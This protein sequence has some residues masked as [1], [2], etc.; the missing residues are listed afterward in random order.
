MKLPLD[1]G[2]SVVV[3]ERGVTLVVGQRAVALPDINWWRT[4]DLVVN[5]KYLANEFRGRS[6]SR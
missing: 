2:N 3:D 5:A 4:D 6:A 1:R